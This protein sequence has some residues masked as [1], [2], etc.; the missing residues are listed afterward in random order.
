MILQGK[1]FQIFK[2]PYKYNQ[3]N[4]LLITMKHKLVQINIC[5]PQTFIFKSYQSHTIFYLDYYFRK[6]NQLLYLTKIINRV[7]LLYETFLMNLTNVFVQ[8]KFI[9]SK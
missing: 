9:L 5:L 1:N 6:V 7:K 8:G 3:F 4:V 2:L